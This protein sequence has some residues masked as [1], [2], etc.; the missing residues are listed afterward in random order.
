MDTIYSLFAILFVIVIV[1][2]QLY[3]SYS[4]MKLK[5]IDKEAK[6]FFWSNKSLERNFDKKTFLIL[7]FL[8]KLFVITLLLSFVPLIIHMIIRNY[9]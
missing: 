6:V 2:N 4:L 3:F 5:K 8:K 9:F 1:I 7:R